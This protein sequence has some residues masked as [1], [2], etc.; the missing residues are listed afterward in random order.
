MSEKK[1]TQA[2]EKLIEIV[3]NAA[4][5]VEAAAVDVKQRIAE[6]TGVKEAAASEVEGSWNPEKISWTQQEG[7]KGPFEKS[8]DF[9]NPDHKEMVKD[10]AAHQG[11]LYRDGV[12]Y[13][14]FQN[15]SVVGRKKLKK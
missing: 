2:E 12:F 15:G 5:A 11:K 6:L 9:N 8:E 7:T 3:L 13:W 4:N 10:L 14:V 1:F